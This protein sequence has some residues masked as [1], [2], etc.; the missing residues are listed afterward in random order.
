MKTSFVRVVFSVAALSSVLFV[1]CHKT[2]E[3]TDPVG[4]DRALPYQYP[5]W[6]AMIDDNTYLS[7]ITIPGA[8][9]CGADLH[10]SEQGVESKNTIC[11]DFRLS[12][13][14][15]MGVRWF[16]VRLGYDNSS[17][18]LSVHHANYYL[19]KNFTDL[20]DQAVAFIHAYPTE[21]VIFMVKQETWTGHKTASDHDFQQAVMSDIWNRPNWQS[22]F[23]LVPGH[24]PKMSEV[25]GKVV[26]VRQYDNA[27]NV[28]NAGMKFAWGDNTTGGYYSNDSINIYVQDNYDI[29]SIPYSTKNYEIEEC[30]R[31]ANAEPD[32][33]RFYLNF[34]SGEEVPHHYLQ[35]TAS[36][37]NHVIDEWMCTPRI[38]RKCGIIMVNFAGGSDDGEIG[39]GFVQTILNC[40]NLQNKIGTQTWQHWNLDVYTYR[41]G[42]S[43]PHVTNPAVWDTLTTG[44]W[45][46]YDNAPGQDGEG[47]GMLYGK[48]YNWYAVHDPRGLAPA[49]WHVPSD[50]EWTELVNYLGGYAVAG[51][52]LKE[53]GH[54]NSPNTGATDEVG[55]HARPGGY[56]Y[57]GDGS[58]AHKGE[59]GFWWSSTDRG[60]VYGPYWMIFSSAAS[61]ENETQQVH[62]NYGMSVRCV[63]D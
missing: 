20:L 7:E 54:W 48:L 18:G 28:G 45:C 40:N 27:L 4:P 50:S 62:K 57:P 12:N 6:M 38:C 19:H 5:N 41:N 39:N 47:N 33:Q 44:A 29:Y 9:D 13:Q 46:Y 58:F 59:S 23:Y 51:G 32:P 61:I 42:D 1:A 3:Q 31:K 14:L 30:V 63:K 25:R 35:T 34:T 55:F 22:D 53:L 26:L 56:F 16:D 2:P 43:I 36:N 10:T 60:T 11:Q 21:A 52:K 49:G 8:H 24:V 17:G 37:I 15:L